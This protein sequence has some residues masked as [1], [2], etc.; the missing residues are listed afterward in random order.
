MISDATLRRVLPAPAVALLGDLIRW[1]LWAV[2]AI[3]WVA[4]GLVY[5]RMIRMALADPAH[6]DFTIF[7]YTSRMVL[8]GQPMYGTSPATYGVAWPFPHL[9]NLNPPHL[10]ALLLPLGYLSYSHALLAWVLVNLACL[11]GALAVIGRALG[12]AWSWPRFW[13]WGALVIA[14]SAF[15]TVAVTGELTF[16]LMLPFT[17]GWRAWRSER[18]V[19]AGAWLGACASA[20]LFVLMYLP[21]LIWRRRW[22]GAAA[23][24]LAAALAF[25]IG[26]AV[27]G[28]ASYQQWVS[29][30]S[31]AT[32][33]WMPM[34]ASW[35]GFVTRVVHGGT[36]VLP[37]IPRLEALRAT[38]AAIAV[39]FAV[40]AFV[41]TRGS[42]ARDRNFLVLLLGALL[43]SPLG[44][45]Y[46]LP[47]GLG[48]LLGVLAPA[49][50]GPGLA[51]LGRGSLAL[52][53]AGVLA[54]YVPQEL[55]L[56]GQPS[57]L[58]TLT[59]AST[60]FWA[61]LSLWLAAATAR[62]A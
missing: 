51:A 30:L 22:R 34:N 10:Q 15:T 2:V 57:G 1:L 19:A 59:I 48:P 42:G 43:T 4:Y 44:W 9:G 28:L 29:T 26:L 13:L 7:Y 27:F 21:W 18:W 17:L 50:R 23:F 46:Y 38:M 16:L 20:K 33:A 8:D 45:V 25:A 31:S 62:T 35:N 41:S 52:G 6:T 61:V 39:I 37:L 47:L 60:Y 32:W 3:V 40:G 24:V 58:A 11:A 14:S 5:V 54:L 12:L 56:R 49:L 53:I 55:T 36:G